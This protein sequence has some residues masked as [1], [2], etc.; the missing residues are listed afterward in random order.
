[1]VLVTSHGFRGATISSSHS[2]AMSAIAGEGTGM[3]TDYDYSSV[4]HAADLESAQKIGR[5][6]GERAVKRLNPRK[7]TTRR[8]PV[9]FDR[10][11]AGT[12][13]SHLA[14]AANGSA[15]ARKSSFLREKRGAQIFSPGIDII[16]DP[17]RR[18]GFRSRPFDAEGVAGS[19]PQNCR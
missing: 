2:V 16:D 5:S 3:E 15:I 4:L 10:R 19:V 12:L 6:A 11:I 17:L 1:M 14:S 8:V 9:V 13:V 7:V 18:R